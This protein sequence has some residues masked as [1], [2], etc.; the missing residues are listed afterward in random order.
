M[1]TTRQVGER[2]QGTIE[3]ALI[4]VLVAMVVLLVLMIFGPDLGNAFSMIT[5]GV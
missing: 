2:G 4:L 1:A 3:Y 5:H